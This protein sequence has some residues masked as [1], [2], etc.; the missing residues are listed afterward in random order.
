MRDFG[1]D[2]LYTMLGSNLVSRVVVEVQNEL[3][4]PVVPHVM[5]DWLGGAYM[6]SV[7]RPLLR[8][9]MRRDWRRAFARSPIKLAIGEA[10]AAEYSRR[11]G[12][13][14]TPFMNAVEPEYLVPSAPRQLDGSPYRLVYVGGLHLNRWRSLREVGLALALLAR[15]GLRAELLVYAHARYKADAK[16]MAVPG[17]T[18][19]MGPIGHSEVPRTLR[20]ADVL[21]HVESFD[22]A[23]RTYTRYS[24]STKIPE[25]MGAR[26]PILAY[27]PHELA[28][29][30][31]VEESG[32]GMSVGRRDPGAL[33]AAL[34]TL[35]ESAGVR[36]RLGSRG[37]TVATTSHDAARQRERFRVIL[38]EA[39]AVRMG[40]GP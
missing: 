3:K 34:R 10:M 39:A 24:V 6:R 29:I 27:G 2:L 22:R 21:L 30:R 35:L 20:E 33:V 17:I 38:A 31:Y 11:F 4:V 1:P 32:S 16:K 25:Y 15:E 18:R 36:E 28:S 9:R 40:S 7:F 23:S 26:R 5:D 19:F 14:F 37:F 13:E 12:G 8:A